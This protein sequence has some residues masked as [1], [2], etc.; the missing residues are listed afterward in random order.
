MDDSEKERWL[1]RAYE[2]ER[3]M[4]NR[5]ALDLSVGDNGE[6]MLSKTKDFDAVTKGLLAELEEKENDHV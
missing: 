4:I 2:I 5:G 3:L 1:K 6:F